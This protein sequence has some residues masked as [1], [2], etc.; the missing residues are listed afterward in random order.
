ML[1]DVD[2]SGELSRHEFEKF[3]QRIKGIAE[4]TRAGDTRLLHMYNARLSTLMDE[5]DTD[6]SNTISIGEFRHWMKD[7]EYRNVTESAESADSCYLRR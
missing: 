6:G 5:I 2:G 3:V 1:A 7:P 4:D